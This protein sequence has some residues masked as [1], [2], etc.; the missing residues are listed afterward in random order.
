MNNRNLALKDAD[1]EQVTTDDAWPE[2]DLS[3]LSIDK[4]TPK[5]PIERFGSWAEWLTVRA[6]ESTAPIDYVAFGFLT[7]AGSL[8]GNRRWAQ[9]RPKWKEPPIIWTILVGDPSFKKSPALDCV[10][11]IVD[12]LEDELRSAW[13]DEYDTY[14][15]DEVVASANKDAWLARIKEASKKGETAPGIPENAKEPEK[16]VEPIFHTADATAAGI[17]NLL[18]DRPV[19]LLLSPDELSGLVENLAAYNANDSAFYIQAYGGR[20][21][22]QT[23]ASRDSFSYPCQPIRMRGWQG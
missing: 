3:L 11:E 22:R 1:M 19:G 18:K 2:P 16:P 10:T 4:G 8:L 6:K 15:I 5:L 12:T 21:H 20:N 14:K 23:R 17:V 13:K 7:I 9:P